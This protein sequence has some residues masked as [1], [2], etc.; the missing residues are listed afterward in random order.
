M[1][2]PGILDLTFTSTN[3]DDGYPFLHFQNQVET[4]MRHDEG[5]RLHMCAVGWA[6]RRGF[7]NEVPT[8]RDTSL[9]AA[10][11]ERLMQRRDV[12]MVGLE[13]DGACGEEMDGLEEGEVRE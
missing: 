6:K 1:I 2:S 10:E 8:G 13:R 4:E 11:R 3:D 12:D 9:S 7:D 5:E